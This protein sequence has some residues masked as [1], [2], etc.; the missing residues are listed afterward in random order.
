[1]RRK[2][3]VRFG[4]FCDYMRKLGFRFDDDGAADAS[5]N[6]LRNPLQ[7][8][9]PAGPE[10]MSGEALRKF[11]RV[12]PSLI[13]GLLGASL[14]GG[15]ILP[16][17]SASYSKDHAYITY[18]PR[19]EGSDAL[20][21][22]VKDLID[23][24]GSVTT[25][26]SRYLK[27]TSPPA[28]QDAACLRIAREKGV[29]INGKTNLG[30]LGTGVSGANDYYGTPINP[31]NPKYR[32]V[33]GGSSSG[34]AVAVATGMADVALGT[35]TAG[36]IRIPAACCG[37]VGMK[38]TFGVVS[39]R[40]VIPLS[41]HL[42]T[43]GPLARDISRLA[44][45]MELLEPDFAERYQAARA[46]HPNAHSI[47]VGRLVVPGTDARIDQAVDEALAKAGFR[48]VKL[49]PEFAKD[50]QLAQSDGKRVAEGDAWLTDHKYLNKKGISDLA[51]AAFRLGHLEYQTNYAAALS[52]QAAWRRE[53]RRVFQKVDLIATP[54]LTKLPPKISHFGRSAPLELR[55]LDIE[56]TDAVNF[57]GNPALAMPIPLKDAPLPVTSLQL[58]GPPHGE[59]AILNA[60][61][62]VESKSGKLRWSPGANSP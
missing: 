14:L 26:G 23:V 20:R 9:I 16:T 10:L 55:V 39:R 54:T 19:P 3:T 58:I 15:C 29:W 18:T 35:D 4:L 11:R 46:E 5:R 49:S 52:R 7:P 42:D 43:V 17:R 37:V 48:V 13:G 62:I 32:Y 56:N 57:A 41:P 27:E 12:I 25:G 45:G 6:D 21:L 34:S 30:E 2:W 33:P 44:Q 28:R 40:G 36:S 31:L 38:T 22:A 53:L 60:G 50:W 59:A 1:M 8:G 61:R 51:K 24:K 47:R